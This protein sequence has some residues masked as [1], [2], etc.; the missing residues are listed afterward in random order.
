LKKIKNNL[1]EK[2]YYSGNAIPTEEIIS[3]KDSKPPIPLIRGKKLIQ[4]FNIF[5]IFF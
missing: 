2:I 4:G 5:F 1:E 3:L